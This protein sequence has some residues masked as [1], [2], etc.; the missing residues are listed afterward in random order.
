MNKATSLTVETIVGASIHKVWEYWTT[1]KHIMH[2]NNASDDWHTPKSENDLRTGGKFCST[3]ASKD[4]KQSFD[5]SGIYDQVEEPCRIKYT[6]E[7][8]RKVTI[9]FTESGHSTVIR[10]IFDVEGSHSTD[11]QKNGWQAILDNFKRYVEG[12]TD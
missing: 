3:M 12:A 7:D 4:G 6:L 1:P 8:G 9:V 10:E 2:W 5:F 11:L